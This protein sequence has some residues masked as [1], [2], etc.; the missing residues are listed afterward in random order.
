MN[1]FKTPSP[2][3]AGFITLAL[4]ALYSVVLLAPV[5]FPHQAK[6]FD[7]SLTQTLLVLL[8]GACGYYLGS[9]KSSDDKTAVIA[10]QVGI[11]P[12]PS[13][14]PNDPVATKEVPPTP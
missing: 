4:L 12:G 6:E 1:G 3:M 7:P 8:V 5:L 13:G 9:S 2:K 11:K 10:A 14:E